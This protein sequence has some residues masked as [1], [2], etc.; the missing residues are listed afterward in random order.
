[1]AIFFQIHEKGID[2]GNAM[3][4]LIEKLKSGNNEDST[5]ICNQDEFKKYPESRI[6]YWLEPAIK[7]SFS[8]FESLK[9]TGRIAAAGLQTNDDFRFIRL[10]WEVNFAEIGR[11]RKWGNFYKGGEFS[12]YVDDIHLVVLWENQGYGI[13]QHTVEL[14]NSPS[15]HVVN[16]NYYFKSG[17][18]YINVSSIG[19]SAQLFPKD[20]IFSIQGQYIESKSILNDLA[21][22]CSSA[23]RSL[24]K[25][26]NPGRHYQA[27]QVQ[28]LPFPEDNSISNTK[29]Y[30]I[31]IC[32]IKYR[33]LSWLETSKYFIRPILLEGNGSLNDRIMK[34]QDLIKIQIKTVLENQIKIDSI[35]NHVYCLDQESIEYVRKN[36]EAVLNNPGI[37]FISSLHFLQ[38]KN[39][40]K[41]W[42]IDS[43]ISYLVG[44]VFG[45][46]KLILKTESPEFEGEI[47]PN[48]PD[49]S[50]S[51]DATRE[52]E[53]GIV[54]DLPERLLSESRNKYGIEIEALLIE[55]GKAESIDDYLGK[56]FF[57]YHYNDY[58]KSRRYAPIYWPIETQNRLYSFWIYYH[59]ITEQTLYFSINNYVDPKLKEVT[60]ELN[61]LSKKLSRSNEE[62][63]N[64][65][66]LSE[67]LGDLRN[68]KDELLRIAGFWK[69]DFND[70]VQ[71]TAAPLWKLFRHK[72][73]QNK[74]KDTW[75]K[76]KKG[77]YDWAHL[78]YNI[79]PDRVLRKCHEDRSM[80]IAHDV[81]SDLWVEEEV[82]VVRR[83]KD[84]GDT[85]A[86]WQPKKLS[87]TELKE[88]IQR[89]IEEMKR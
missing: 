61:N 40:A 47:I 50:K 43:Y 33:Q 49:V 46:W 28:L 42:I 1:V 82:A 26:I 29:P 39:K 10:S 63:K 17:L 86:V 76:L 83:G 64:L 67:L 87:E 13:K 24:L 38:N 74:L 89:K 56:V 81:E 12:P 14:G 54:I 79:W 35:L 58:S 16:E 85:K 59:G 57:D 69:P 45:R 31:E 53:I 3:L 68:L 37:P 77:E 25:V 7:N 23:A 4:T 8:N 32:K 11:T 62:E 52:N 27:G 55:R 34:A 19:F 9:D 51:F 71:I 80:A 65:S 66:K 88:L 21:V 41:D 78:A 18:G 60:N 73:W 36:N 30:V 6:L 15:R 72:P 22:C 48:I 20:V 84:S 2:R 5:F 70:G 75:E 44:V